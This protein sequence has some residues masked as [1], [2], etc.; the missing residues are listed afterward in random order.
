M[1]NRKPLILISNDDGYH[2]AGIRKLAD[3]VKPLADILVVAPE[4]ARSGY[5]C[6]FSA[7]EYLRIKP[8]HNMGEVNVWS[9]SGT[10][11]DCVKIALDQLCDGRQPDLIISGINHGDNSSVNNRY[12]G[13][14]GVAYEGCMKFIP[15]IAFSSCFYHEDANL[16]P[17]RPY[18]EKIVTKVLT[19]GLPQGICLNVNF[20]ARELFEG[21][22]VCR[23]TMGRWVNE[24]VKEHHPRGYDYFWVVGEYHNDEP[25]AI[26]S[27]Q[28]ALNN[29]Y[30]A[31]TPTQI[32]VTAY[33]F[34]DE[35]R[36]WKL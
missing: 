34:M 9:C 12:S 27:D 18:I 4:S 6:A 22:K 1:Q 25:E 8:R 2:S 28:W 20:P 36:S 32:D 29:G 14:M 35:V 11:V 10:P 17:L 33:K 19:H 13:T 5:S 7:T 16:E 31:I 26:D 3:I 30:V 24:M 15:S 21:V 23:M